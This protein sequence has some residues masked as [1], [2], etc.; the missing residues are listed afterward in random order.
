MSWGAGFMRNEVLKPWGP[1]M[2]TFGHSGMGRR[3][4]LHRP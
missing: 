1:G 4:Y 3:L 2:Q